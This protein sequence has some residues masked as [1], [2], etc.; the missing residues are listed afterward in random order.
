MQ[1]QEEEVA[2]WKYHPTQNPSGFYTPTPGRLLSSFNANVALSSFALH[3]ICP[4]LSHGTSP[5]AILIGKILQELYTVQSSRRSPNLGAVANLKAQLTNWLDNIPT[6][7]KV[8][9]HNTM[10]KAPPSILTL[11]TEYW[12]AVI[13]LHRPL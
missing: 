13:L 8:T 10:F 1:G 4:S 5:L 12:C 3:P 6:Y 9:D 11:H 2:L 7:L